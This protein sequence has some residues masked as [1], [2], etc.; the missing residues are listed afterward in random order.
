MAVPAIIGQL[1]GAGVGLLGGILG[2]KSQKKAADRAAKL[3]YDA[4]MAGVNETRRQFDL[5]RADFAGEQQ[6]GEDAIGGF[7]GLVG[8]NGADEQQAAIMALR[9]SPLYQSLYRNGEEAT[10]ANA[11]ATGGIRGGNTQRSLYELGEDTLS[12]VI[13]QQLGNL[14]GAIGIGTGADGAVGSFGA[15][16]VN[17]QSMLRNQGADAQ[18]QAALIRGGVNAQNWA[19]VGTLLSGALG[20]IKF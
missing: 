2:G 1:L 10:L 5:T 19:N 14:G 4:A 8:L 12:R 9:E 7:R 11:S 18:G 17:T 16:A 3:Q 13:Q 6:L 15:N 20:K